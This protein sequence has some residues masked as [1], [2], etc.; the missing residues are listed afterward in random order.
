[1]FHTAYILSN[2]IIMIFS[3]SPN[4]PVEMKNTTK[5]DLKQSEH[6]RETL[7]IESEPLPIREQT[8]MLVSN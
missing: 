4:E 8:L 7:P 2:H 6:T 5:T 3:P 1:M